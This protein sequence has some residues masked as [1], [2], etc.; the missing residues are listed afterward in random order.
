[1]LE[2]PC[3]ASKMLSSLHHFVTVAAVE[4][5]E[6]ADMAQEMVLYLRILS[7]WLLRLAKMFRPSS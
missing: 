7:T 6:G 1:M 5:E 3:Q 2:A 4:S